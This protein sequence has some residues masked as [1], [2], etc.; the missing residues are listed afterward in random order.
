MC[1]IFLNTR[2]CFARKLSSV[3]YK[4]RK[5]LG[6]VGKALILRRG[7]CIKCLVVGDGEIYPPPP[8]YQD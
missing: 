5:G 2:S 4:L 1:V 7:V 3:C 6:E 8:P